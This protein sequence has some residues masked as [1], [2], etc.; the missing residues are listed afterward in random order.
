[1]SA[2]FASFGEAVPYRRMEHRRTPEH[3]LEDAMGGLLECY[4]PEE[5]RG[6]LSRIE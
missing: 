6:C 1:M 5:G 2:S 3:A 4:D